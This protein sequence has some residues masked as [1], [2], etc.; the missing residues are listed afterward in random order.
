[1]DTQYENE[2]SYYLNTHLSMFFLYDKE[3]LDLIEKIEKTKDKEDI[4]PEG[5]GSQ[6]PVSDLSDNTSEHR[7]NKNLRKLQKTSKTS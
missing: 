1:M 3:V 2:G 4:L 7:Q 6:T 5:D